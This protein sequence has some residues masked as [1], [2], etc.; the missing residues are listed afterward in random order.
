[1]QSPETQ[2]ARYSPIRSLPEKG[3]SARAGRLR[4][5]PRIPLTLPDCVPLDKLLG[6]PRSGVEFLPPH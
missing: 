5:G 1:M 6:F 3:R 4:L 2:V